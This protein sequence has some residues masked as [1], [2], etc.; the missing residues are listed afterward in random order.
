MIA[1]I[2]LVSVATTMAQVLFEPEA[3]PTEFLVKL[4]LFCTIAGAVVIVTAIRHTPSEGNGTRVI[5]TVTV[6]AGIAL[7]ATLSVPMLRWP[8]YIAAIILIVYAPISASL[9]TLA[10]ISSVRDE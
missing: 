2:D 4:G 3:F 7:I 1:T 9:D 6:P 5:A 10:L 8:L